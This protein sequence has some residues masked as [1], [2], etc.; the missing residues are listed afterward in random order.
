MRIL[1]L[2]QFFAPEPVLMNM[3]F[4]RALQAEGHEV[5]VLTGL[6]N[7]PGGTLYPGYT[8]KLVQREEI[9]GV[10]ITRVPLYASHS[11]SK[12]GRIA[13]YVSFAASASIAGTFS[14]WRPDVIYV[15]HPPLTVGLAA[16]IIGLLR[17]VPFVYNIQDLWPDTL[18]ATGMIGNDRV[19]TC[20]AHV[21]K[22]VYKRAAMLLPQSP[23]FAQRLRDAGVPD[24]KI[25]VLYNWA[26]EA[27]FAAPSAWQKPEALHGKFV[28][29]FAG[30][31]GAAQGLDA[32]LDAAALLLQTQ[33]N[34][35]LVFIGGGTEHARL[36]DLAAARALSNVLFL[37]AVP[38][39][40]I[41]AVLAAA[42]VLLVHLRDDPLF[43]ITIPS[44]TQAYLLAGKPIIMGV[45]GD[46]AAL[47]EQ[48]QAGMTVPPQD[49]A[50]LADA[51]TRMAALSS[52]ERASMGARGKAYY[53]RTL[54]LA[55]ASRTVLETLKK[56]AA[57][58]A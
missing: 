53:Q 17:G 55:A 2:S 20:I 19:L 43:A 35:R 11:R 24:G 4:A 7:Y 37:P 26:D 32:V 40:Q 49:A 33:P 9:D 54:S 39:Q 18:K 30:T 12:L 50:A 58:A 8:L 3:A 52:A 25:R 5:R 23:G 28:V 38:M 57:K 46:A 6:P 44:K 36:S 29:T 14:G 1:I 47:V 31:M 15:Y 10:R 51:I 21:A 42:D 16:W 45:R 13:N 56:A 48:A 34:T 27:A 22:F 41:G